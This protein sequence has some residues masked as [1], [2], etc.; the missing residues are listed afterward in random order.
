MQKTI[1]GLKEMD[2]PEVRSS[3][4]QLV[5]DMS[6]ISLKDLEISQLKEKNQQL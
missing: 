3:I 5:K 2:V 4:D 1:D 6:E